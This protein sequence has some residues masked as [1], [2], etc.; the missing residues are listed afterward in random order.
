MAEIGIVPGVYAVF[1]DVHH[2]HLYCRAAVS[3]HCHRWPAD[4]AGADAVMSDITELSGGI[5]G[6]RSMKNRR[7]LRA[8]NVPG[9]R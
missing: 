1:V 7:I 5:Y 2:R 3:N 6:V 8:E 4:I 9:K